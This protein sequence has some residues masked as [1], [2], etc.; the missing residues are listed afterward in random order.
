MVTVAMLLSVPLLAL[1]VKLSAP[2]VGGGRRV[3][4]VWSC[5]PDKRAVCAGLA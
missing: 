1:K 3:G 2:T 4:E 5:S